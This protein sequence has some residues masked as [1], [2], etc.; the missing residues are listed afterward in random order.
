MC[1]VALVCAGCADLLQDNLQLSYSQIV[2]IDRIVATESC[3]TEP[4]GHRLIACPAE[5][6]GD[7]E[8]ACV[9]AVIHGQEPNDRDAELLLINFRE[10][11]PVSAAHV[12]KEKG[13]WLMVISGCRY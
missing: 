7:W 6:N 13:R 3:N 10:G 1:V 4:R 11:K 8:D 12:M 2:A 5:L 9:L